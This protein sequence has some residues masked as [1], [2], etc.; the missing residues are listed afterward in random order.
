MAM[1]RFTIPIEIKFLILVVIV[2]ILCGIII[3][4]IYSASDFNIGFKTMGLYYPQ[5]DTIVLFKNN[6]NY[7]KHELCHRKQNY[8]NRSYKKAFGRFLNEI[9][10]YTKQHI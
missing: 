6:T 1:R 4:S 2:L 5:N 10:C 8:E 9:E 3:P 7:L